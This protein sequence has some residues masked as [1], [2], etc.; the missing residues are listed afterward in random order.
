MVRASQMST[1]SNFKL[2][3]Y[4]LP[5]QTPP[6]VFPIFWRK[7]GGFLFP[8]NFGEALLVLRCVHRNYAHEPPAPGV[9]NS[10]KGPYN[11]DKLS[12]SNECE[13]HGYRHIWNHVCRWVAWR[14]ASAD[15]SVR[16]YY[17]CVVF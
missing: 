15:V 6:F 7:P 5:R 8:Q 4:L 13:R 2:M 11:F 16:Q 1:P 3:H 10:P 14:V 9:P 12:S 17:K